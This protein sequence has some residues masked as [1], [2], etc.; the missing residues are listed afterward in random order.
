M[1]VKVMSGDVVNI[2]GVSYWNE[3]NTTMGNKNLAASDIISAL[4]TTPDGLAASKG[5]TV[6]GLTTGNYPAG[7]TSSFLSRTPTDQTPMAFI[8]YI[9]FDEQFHYVTGGFSKVDASGYKSATDHHAD[10]QNIPVTK[11]GYLYVYCSNQSPVN[12]YFDNLQVILDH[13][14]LIEETHYYPFG[15]TMSG[16]SSSAL[17]FG[18]PDNKKLYNGK[19]I[20]NKEFTDGSGLELYDY[21]ARMQDPQL[22]RFWT[23]DP[24]AEKVTK[25]SP[26]SYT[27]DNPLKFI[28]MDGNL[29]MSIF[30]F[31]AYLGVTG[32]P[33]QVG[34]YTVNKSVAGF[35]QGALGISRNTTL[36]VHFEEG[37][38][39]SSNTHAMTIGNTIFYNKNIDNQGVAYFTSL[40][41]HEEHHVQDYDEMGTIPFIGSYYSQMAKNYFGRD[42]NSYDSYRNIGTEIKG[43]ENGDVIDKFFQ[44]SQNSNDFFAILNNGNLSENKKA[45]QL[46]ALGLERIQLP[47]LTNLSSGL[48]NSL[49]NLLKSDGLNSTMDKDFNEKA[50]L[51]T[52]SVLQL[53]N[54]V[55]KAIQNTKDKIKMLR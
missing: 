19:E 1:T 32:Q 42:E 27:F 54:N 33:S 35:L 5:A 3:A 31:H 41:A 13:G 28:D 11:N 36:N 44:N 38:L 9:L 26:Y 10:L 25:W 6:T 17:N 4:L 24:M 53:L 51:L 29:P 46:E 16:I 21:S 8:N 40:I 37:S 12:V 23:I 22:G 20:Q 52:K 39:L 15:L 43:F 34:Y 47:G 14:P 2:F 50:S 48:N 49:N 55:Q 30:T 45:D 18:Q 7:I